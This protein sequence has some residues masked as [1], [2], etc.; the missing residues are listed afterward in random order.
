ME[1]R[2]VRVVVCCVVVGLAFTTV[3]KVFS[4]SLY[5]TSKEL[6][7]PTDVHVSVAVVAVSLEAAKD[8]GAGQAGM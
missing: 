6:G 3:E 8:V 1:L 2:P 5:S 4:P 7:V